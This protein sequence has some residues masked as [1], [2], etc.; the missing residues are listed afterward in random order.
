V[1]AAL[2]YEWVRIT[3]IR[4]TRI[5][6]VLAL[7]FGLGLGYLA[8]TPEYRNFDDAGMPIGEPTVDWYGAFGFPLLL[9]VVLASIVAAQSIGQEYRFGLIRLT[10][11]AFP[12]RA[13]ILSAKVAV[14]VLACA[15]IAL[16]SYLGSWIGVT[17]RGFP[18]PPGD[19][20]APDSTYLVRG[21][22]YLVLWGLSAFALAGITRQTAIGI[23]VPIISGFILENILASLLVDRA[24]WLTDVLPW[25]TANRWLSSP[26]E[27]SPEPG[28]VVDSPP[29]AWAALGVFAVWV[30][31]LLAAQVVSFLKRDA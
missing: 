6:M 9:A 8:S 28:F 16:L 22:A 19:V 18:T 30:A 31:V 2:R 24:R 10:L 29:A 4:S 13:R 5:S 1:T 7:L 11:T 15:T 14:V 17:L 26:T 21:V 3:T 20:V 27:V 23:A 12:Q 25:S